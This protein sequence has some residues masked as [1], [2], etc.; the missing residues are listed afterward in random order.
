MSKSGPIIE[1]RIAAK[2]GLRALRNYVGDAALKHA[3]IE[4]GLAVPGPDGIIETT[5]VEPDPIPV[6][7]TPIDVVG[8][9]GWAVK[10]LKKHDVMTLED[11]ASKSKFE[12]RRL[13]VYEEAKKILD[14]HGLEPRLADW[15]APGHD[16]ILDTKFKDIRLH[17]DNGQNTPFQNALTRACIEKLGEL[18]EITE[19]NFANLRGIGH[20]S[21]LTIMKRLMFEHG[22]AF[23]GEQNASALGHAGKPKATP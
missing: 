12:L 4:L 2:T 10:H 20:G 14:A 1:R 15:E 22:I 13:Y 3:L 21:R 7:G 8:F 19:N 11:L 16:P 23:K 17:N 9:E 18:T 5:A 6:S